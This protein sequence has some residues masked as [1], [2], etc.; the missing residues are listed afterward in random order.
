MLLFSFI[1][2]G[3]IITFGLLLIRLKTFKPTSGVNP[4]GS[5]ENEKRAP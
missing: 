5:V 1:L 2:M 3:L 4:K